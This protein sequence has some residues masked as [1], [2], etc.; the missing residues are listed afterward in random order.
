[1]KIVIKRRSLKALVAVLFY[2]AMLDYAYLVFL[3]DIF[4]YMGITE[5]MNILKVIISYV[6]LIGL[7]M[8]TPTGDYKIY[9][10]FVNIQLLIMIIP[11]LT[12]YGVTDE[13]TQY[14]VMVQGCYVVQCLVCMMHKEHASV[15]VNRTNTDFNN[16][17]LI[18]ALLVAGISILKFGIPS[19][20]ALNI[21]RVYEIRSEYA[22]SFPLSYLVPWCAKII[23]PFGFILS[24]EEKKYGKGLVYVAIQMILY[25]SFAHKT[26]LFMII[27]A[28]GVWF[29]CRKG[30]LYQVLYMIFPLGVAGSILIYRLIGNILALSYFVRRVLIVPATLKFAYFEYYSVHP[31]ACFYKSIIGKIFGLESPYNKSIAEQIGIYIGEPGVMANTGYF[32]EGYAQG[33]YF[34]LIIM[35]MFLMVVCKMCALKRNINMNIFLTMF[36]LWFYTLNDVALQTSLITGGGAV[37][38]FAFAI[39]PERKKS[40][41][42]LSATTPKSGYRRVRIRMGK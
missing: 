1:M 15:S 7:W 22:L 19:L 12:M 41:T 9:D 25:L 33:G 36:I 18:I 30:C 8:I 6:M 20:T 32:G 23:V 26:Y 39:W 27:L 16:F 2:K 38:L 24:L 5:D 42:A 34:V 35:A 11:M 31:K 37:L 17:L 14:F 13:S 40:Y 29:V 10:V 4:D 28:G 21:T 3:T